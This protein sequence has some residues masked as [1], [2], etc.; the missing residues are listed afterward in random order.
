[1]QY[2]KFKNLIQL[3]EAHSLHKTEFV[4]NQTESNLENKRLLLSHII[5]VVSNPVN[6][7]DFKI[8]SSL[9]DFLQQ[10]F[11]LKGNGVF[12]CPYEIKTPYGDGKFFDAHTYFKDYKYP[13][14]VQKQYCHS[15]SY[16]FARTQNCKCKVLS[17]IAF[18]KISFLHSVVQIDD[19]I[20]DFNYDIMMSKDLYYNLFNFVVINEVTSEDI[21]KN[22]VLMTTKL[23]N[24]INYGEMN[25]CYYELLEMV[26][27][28]Q[29]L[30]I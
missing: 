1:M 21:V 14:F 19:Y 8:I 28:N 15:N 16:E 11:N 23:A 20:L 27:N 22:S 7:Q 6:A 12:S 13:Y 29:E 9:V 30:I 25:F 4:K 26:Q 3:S 10:K 5:Q 2:S 17:G 18:K 24:K